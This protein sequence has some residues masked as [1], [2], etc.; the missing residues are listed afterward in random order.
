MFSRQTLRSELEVLRLGVRKKG[1]LT[2]SHAFVKAKNY[3]GLLM[4]RL[5]ILVELQPAELG[6]VCL[7]RGVM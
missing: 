6:V 1:S 4:L 2:P 3:Y 7:V 5:E